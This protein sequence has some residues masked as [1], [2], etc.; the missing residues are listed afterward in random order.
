MNIQMWKSTF[1]KH[2]YNLCD[3]KIN[4]FITIHTKFYSKK[5]YRMLNKF[6]FHEDLKKVSS[7]NFKNEK[8]SK[9]FSES[10]DCDV[11]NKKSNF[12]HGFV[13]RDLLSQDVNKNHRKIV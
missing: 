3:A 13:S 12:I 9:L 5:R 10:N 11:G 2:C 4:K 1:S 8:S 7:E 6:N